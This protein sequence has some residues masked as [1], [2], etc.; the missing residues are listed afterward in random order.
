MVFATLPLA[1]VAAFLW[2]FPVVYGQ[3]PSSSTATSS[4]AESQ[5]S[6]ASDQPFSTTFVPESSASES[7]SNGVPSSAEVSTVYSEE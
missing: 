7:S 3:D 6:E 1:G 5:W 4:Q 2:I